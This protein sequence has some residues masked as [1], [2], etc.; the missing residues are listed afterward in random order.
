MHME[1]NIHINFREG[2]LTIIVENGGT[3]ELSNLPEDEKRFLEN[4]FYLLRTASPGQ[5]DE[6]ENLIKA[7]MIHIGGMMK[8]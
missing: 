5:R 6:T 2:T 4:Y 8:G 1:N 7:M 3:L